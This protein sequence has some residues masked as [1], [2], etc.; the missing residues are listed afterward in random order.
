MLA[1]NVNKWKN[2][3]SKYYAMTK[4]NDITEIVIL[5]KIKTPMTMYHVQKNKKNTSTMYL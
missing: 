5:K 1:Y 3:F 4:S 2:Q